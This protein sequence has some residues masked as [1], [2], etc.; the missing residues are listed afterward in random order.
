[1]TAKIKI[2]KISVTKEEIMIMRVPQKNG[3]YITI[4]DLKILSLLW[5]S[6][7]YNS[8]YM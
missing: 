6:Q 3:H 7:T 8:V 2:G 5:F 1:M 4:T